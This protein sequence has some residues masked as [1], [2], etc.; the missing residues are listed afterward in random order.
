MFSQR[1]RIVKT[2]FRSL[3]ALGD[4]NRRLANTSWFK[5]SPKR[6][7]NRVAEGMKALEKVFEDFSRV[8][9]WRSG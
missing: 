4:E 7:A 2:N 1:G 9:S 6:I 5:F 8:E 3:K